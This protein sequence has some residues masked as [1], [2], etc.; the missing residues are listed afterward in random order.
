[1]PSYY[2][3]P[4]L[5]WPVVSTAW[6]N[7]PPCLTAGMPLVGRKW[8]L[9]LCATRTAGGTTGGLE[10]DTSF[11]SGSSEI[12]CRLVQALQCIDVLI[13]VS[14]LCDNLPAC[15]LPSFMPSFQLLTSPDNC[16]FHFIL[17][18]SLSILI[19]N[20]LEYYYSINSESI[21]YFLLFIFWDI[22]LRLD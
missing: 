16:I 5:T 13:R 12:C 14:G 8:L 15:L 2:T 6:D 19:C 22:F 20:R 11:V 10:K 17:I 4:C 7:S 1:M 3:S 21:N 9:A 18:P